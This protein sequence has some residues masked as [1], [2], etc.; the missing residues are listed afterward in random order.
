MRPVGRPPYGD[1]SKR[2]ISL[3]VHPLLL[4]ELRELAA[5][6]GMPY[7]SL[8]HDILEKNVAR[9]MRARKR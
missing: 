3:R 1:A 9:M 2:L 5:E 4:T 8:M 6:L 7:Q